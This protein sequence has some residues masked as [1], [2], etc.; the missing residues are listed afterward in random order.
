[1]RKWFHGRKMRSGI[2]SV[3][4]EAAGYILGKKRQ[5]G[6][7]GASLIISCQVK[8]C[9][10]DLIGTVVREVVFS[11]CFLSGGN[12]PW[13]QRSLPLLRAMEIVSDSFLHL[14]VTD[15]ELRLGSE[16]KNK[17]KQSRFFCLMWLKS[18]GDILSSG[19][20]QYECQNNDD[21]ISL[22]FL[23]RQRWP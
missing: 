4:N 5:Y 21:P 1:M 17:T 16:I 15:P 6:H 11:N 10:I 13:G 22:H 14:Q 2:V 3:I 12:D 20:T 9:V 23:L 18:P 7:L 8:C 19:E